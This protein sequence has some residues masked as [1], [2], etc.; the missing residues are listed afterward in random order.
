MK[1]IFLL[2]IVLVVFFTSCDV[3]D[4]PICPPLGVGFRED[5]Y[6]PPPEFDPQATVLTNVLLEDFTGQQ[7]GNCPPANILARDLDTLFGERLSIVTIHAGS[8]AAT[9]PDYPNDY[10][11]P[12]GDFYWS[13]LAFQA[14]PEGRINRKGGPSNFFTTPAW[15]DEITESLAV[16]GVLDLQ[17]AAEY[18]AENQHLNVHVYSRFTEAMPDAFRLV[19][20]VI[21]S[22]IV[23]HQLWYGHIPPEVPDYVHY[24]MLRGSVTGASGEIVFTNPDA[25][26]TL[27]SSYSMDWNAAWIAENCAVVAF[28]FNESTGA[29]VTCTDLELGE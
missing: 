14:Y 29:I 21:E 6:G 22:K 19:V 3:I 28:I 7:C 13:Q 1:K 17:L 25:D 24:H 11:T 8:L 10:T 26:A 16:P 4:E 15:E 23:D 9:G 5:L 18:V 2:T 12:E 27:V 20:L